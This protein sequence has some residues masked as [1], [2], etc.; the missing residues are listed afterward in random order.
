MHSE[1]LHTVHGSCGGGSSEATP[2]PL[3]PLVIL[4]ERGTLPSHLPVSPLAVRPQPLAAGP[5]P[6]AEGPFCGEIL[7]FASRACKN[8]S[9]C[10]HA[11]VIVL[12]ETASKFH[13]ASTT[14]CAPLLGLR[15][16]WL[17]CARFDL[18][19]LIGTQRPAAPSRLPAIPQKAHPSFLRD[20]RPRG[21]RPQGPSSGCARTT[22]R[23]GPFQPLETTQ[24]RLTRNGLCP[25]DLQVQGAFVRTP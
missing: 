13:A 11:A 23:V 24:P 7:V 2:D 18:H 20:P 5:S 14:R 12:R 15:R 22:L 9:T 8:A 10:G 4:V 16:L 21:R 25:H 1:V 17:R 19:P 3:S 6:R